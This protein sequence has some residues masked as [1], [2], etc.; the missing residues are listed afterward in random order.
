MA[1][2]LKKNDGSTPKVDLSK[3]PISKFNLTKEGAPTVTGTPIVGG[4]GKN[5]G[6]KKGIF[7][8]IAIV[9]VGIAAWLL[10]SK[11]PETVSAPEVTAVPIDSTSIKPQVTADSIA[12]ANADEAQVSSNEVA[13]SEADPNTPVQTQK[14]SDKVVDGNQKAENSSQDATSQ[15]STLPQGTIEEKAKQVIRG[16]FGNGIERKNALGSEY[17]EIQKKV[18][19][20]LRAV[21]L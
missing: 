5:G 15:V 6:S 7:I 9:V 2:D 1:F 17:K 11:S 12:L 4:N 19:E 16:D 21:K 13:T 20:M 14:A 3:K 18:N 10:F 8:L